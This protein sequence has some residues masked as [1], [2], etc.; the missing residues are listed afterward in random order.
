MERGRHFDCVLEDHCSSD[1][2]FSAETVYAFR[3]AQMA[4]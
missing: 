3:G 2:L 4:G 1:V